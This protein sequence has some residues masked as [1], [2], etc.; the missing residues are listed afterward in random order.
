MSKIKLTPLAKRKLGAAK[1]ALNASMRVLALQP[2]SK[3]PDS[4]FVPMARIARP[5]T[6]WSSKNGCA[7][8]HP[9]TLVP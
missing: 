9:S 1:A 3:A 4:A 6:P 8:T 2:R 5:M 7:K